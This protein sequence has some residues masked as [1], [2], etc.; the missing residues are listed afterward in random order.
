M[1]SLKKRYQLSTS[2]LLTTSQTKYNIVFNEKYIIIYPFNN[3]IE[4][5]RDCQ[6]V[7]VNNLSR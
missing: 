2:F 1:L 5:A 7:C 3:K 4:I 6:E